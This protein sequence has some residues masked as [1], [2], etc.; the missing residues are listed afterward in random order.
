MKPML[1]ATAAL[2]FVSGAALAQTTSVQSAPPALDTG[3][4]AYPAQGTVSPSTPTPEPTHP[5]KAHKTTRHHH[6]THH[7]RHHTAPPASS[8]TTGATAP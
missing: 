5:R 8:D 4:N 3:S 2:L 7:T 1:A 6:T